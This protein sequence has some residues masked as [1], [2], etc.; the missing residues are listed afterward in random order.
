MTRLSARPAPRL[1]DNPLLKPK[2]PLY[3]QVRRAILMSLSH[4]VLRAGDAL[5][6]EAV[7][8]ERY[9]VSVGTVRQAVALLAREGVL[10]RTQGVGTFVTSYSTKPYIN[11]FH[12]FTNDAAGSIVP[13]V[14]RLVRFERVAASAHPQA[15]GKLALPRSAE[16]I[17]ALRVYS[18]QN[19]DAG[20]SELWLPAERFCKMTAENLARHA[21][22]LYAYYE[23]DLGVSIIRTEDS[24]R[25]K[26]FTPEL[27]ALGQFSAGAPYLELSRVSYSFDNQ[28]VEYRLSCC[29]TEKYHL[30]L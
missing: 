12:R 1:P 26:I 15:A 16:L 30:E 20:I 5:P 28:P 19:E 18:W 23:R 11:A 10:Q 3:E 24:F 7:L 13:F 17:H 29:T 27:A 25:A 21:G 14:M 22:S 2:L 4:G 9:H 8:A 6:S